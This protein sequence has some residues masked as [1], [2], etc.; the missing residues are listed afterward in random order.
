V[1]KR[2]TVQ[3]VIIALAVALVSVVALWA[4]PAQAINVDPGTGQPVNC[5]P[6][7]QI[8]ASGGDIYFKTYT[9]CNNY[10][11]TIGM[12]YFDWDN[13]TYEGGT[14]KQCWDYQCGVTGVT[15]TLDDR[16]GTQRWGMDIYVAVLGG[17]QPGDYCCVQ[18]TYRNTSL[19]VYYH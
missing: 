2:R 12:D 14:V 11:Y 13:S 3:R 1:V 16:P 7:Y 6:R 15:R 17:T 19:I 18:G 5:K 4:T 10:Y 9:Y 8:W